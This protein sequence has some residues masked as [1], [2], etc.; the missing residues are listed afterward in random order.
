MTKNTSTQTNNS[1]WL[2]FDL[3]LDTFADVYGLLFAAVL[4]GAALAVILFLVVVYV[5]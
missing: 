5:L 3:T 2:G 1:T 4:T